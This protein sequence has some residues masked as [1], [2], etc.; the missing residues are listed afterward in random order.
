MR[1]IADLTVKQ[2]RP[3]QVDVIPFKYLVDERNIQSIRNYCDFKNFEPISSEKGIIEGFIFRNGVFS[4]DDERYVVLNLTIGT[5]KTEFKIMSNSSIASQFYEH[6]RDIINSFDKDGRFR[7]AL[8]IL[9]LQ[10]TNCIV[11]LD[12][13]FEDI[14]SPRFMKYLKGNVVKNSRLKGTKN[15]I[16]PVRFSGLISYQPT[17]EKYNEQFVTISSEFFT[18]E[19]R[20]KT[21]EEERRYFSESPTDSDT[22]LSLIEEFEKIFKK[23]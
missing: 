4:F 23:S 13:D 11:T 3:F 19:P 6:I 7:K 5:R 22:H 15:H 9:E 12:V 17:D 1:D 10:A 16:R 20:A 2:L 14:Y 18:I 21:A 8:P